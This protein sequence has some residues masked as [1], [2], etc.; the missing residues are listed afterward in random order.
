MSNREGTPPGATA[1]GIILFL[2]PQ[3]MWPV[4]ALRGILAILFG[5]V[6]LLWPGITLLVLA[7][8]FGAWALL[9]GISLLANAFRQGRAHAR[10]HDWVPSLLAGLLG[11]AVAVVTVLVPAI[12]VL[13]LTIVAAILLIGVGV[14]E[15]AIAVGLRR[16][17]RG[18]VF[19]VLS[20]LAGIIAGIVILLWPLSGAL[21]LTFMLGVYALVSGILLLA[22]AWRVHHLARVGTASIAAGGEHRGRA[23][24]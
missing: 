4:M 24:C 11:I 17:I 9:D 22:V 5:I 16:L 3:K 2:N 6:A 10:W 15:I 14:A 1:S 12:T 18:E 21:V 23:L 20:G 13:V 7:L 8:L 19:L